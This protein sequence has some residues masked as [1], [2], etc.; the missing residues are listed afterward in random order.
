MADC[1][2]DWAPPDRLSKV[3]G[4]SKCILQCSQGS[5]NSMFWATTKEQYYTPEFQSRKEGSSETWQD[6]ADALKTLVERLEVK[7]ILA[8]VADT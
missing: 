7:E 2:D 3:S 8:L 1:L 4:G 6:F 5:L